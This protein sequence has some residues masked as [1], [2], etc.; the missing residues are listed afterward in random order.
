MTPMLK[1]F[2]SLS[3]IMENFAKTKGLKI[4]IGRKPKVT[5]WEI[6][7]AFI[8]SYLTHMPVLKFFQLN[9]DTSIRSYHIF[10]RYRIQR[11]YKLLRDFLKFLVFLKIIVQII[12]KRIKRLLIDG[13]ILS[14]ANI[15]R[16][17]THNIK[18]FSGKKFWVKRKRRLYSPHY[19]DI[20]EFEEIHYGV[21]V[22]VLC[23]E[24]GFI[25]DIWYTYGSMHEKKAF[26]IRYERSY[27]FRFLVNSFNVIGDKAYK[28]IKNLMI[29]DNKELKRVRQ[30][31]ETSI[32]GTKGFYYS[33]WRK[34]ITLLSYLYGFA[35]GFSLLRDLN[36]F[37]K[38]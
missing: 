32:G 17:R 1:I 7:S 11:V 12:S 29:C 3:Q 2:Y 15:N 4:S 36:A 31:V 6:A 38:V 18:R 35:L 9:I 26:D 34:G 19:K 27:W 10:R 14:V 16:A 30:M 22:I 20:V 13:T 33:R 23:D 8:I 37:F 25:Y 24:D 5:D 28:G 21:L